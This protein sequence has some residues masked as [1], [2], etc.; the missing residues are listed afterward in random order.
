MKNIFFVMLMVLTSSVFAADVQ[1]DDGPNGLVPLPGLIQDLKSSVAEVSLLDAKMVDITT[2]NENALKEYKVLAENNKQ[3]LAAFEQTK[4]N[5]I[6]S[7]IVPYRKQKQA[8]MAAVAENYNSRCAEN[9]VGK[10]PQNQYDSCVQLKSQAANQI[11][12]ITQEGDQH[13]ANL[14]VEFDRTQ[15]AP[16]NNIILR[17]NARIQQLNDFIKANFASWENVR[18]S[19]VKLRK[20]IDVLE[21][22]IRNQCTNAQPQTMKWCNSVSWDGASKKLKPLPG[23]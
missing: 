17:Q 12:Q 8:E 23:G 4:A 3:V 1:L 9:R 21:G 14:S 11:A 10:L 18:A 22:M 20:H 13:L 5:Y 15:T 6:N 16:T 19:N 2:A 7:V